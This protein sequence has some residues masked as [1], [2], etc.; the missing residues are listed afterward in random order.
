MNSYIR[1]MISSGEGLRLDFK[2]EISDSKKIARTLSAFA[3]TDGGTLL[4]GVKDNGRI[5]GVRSDEEYYMLESAAQ[6]HCNP[7]VGFTVRQWH[8]DGKTILEAKIEKSVTPPHYARSEE[9]KWLAYIRV[10]DENLL[11]NNIMIKV[12]KRRN[13]ESGT[14][15][16][17]SEKEKILFDYLRENETITLSMFQR[18]SRTNNYIAGNILVNLIVLGLIGIRIKDKKI[19]YALKD[20]NEKS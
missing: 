8:V 10:N 11:A 12:W 19:V 6:L 7:P 3:N 1:N 15:V 13:R 2:F 4:V 16:R 17:Y 14:L 18:I 9:G 5:A 20:K